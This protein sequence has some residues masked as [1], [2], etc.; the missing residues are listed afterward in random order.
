[1]PGRIG[2][3]LAVEKLPREE[4]AK[5]DKWVVWDPAGEV[6]GYISWFPRWSQYTFNPA[7]GQALPLGYLEEVGNF[8]KTL[9]GEG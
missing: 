2:E 6:L 7:P 4:G 8:I 3:L 9:N 1:M 5:T